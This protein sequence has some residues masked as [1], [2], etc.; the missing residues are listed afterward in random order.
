MHLSA[1][2]RDSNQGRRFPTAVSSYQSRVLGP[3]SLNILIVQSSSDCYMSCKM[4]IS[5]PQLMLANYRH[6]EI[7]V[8]IRTMNPLI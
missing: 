1:E 3:S 5:A 7:S 8:Y 6:I 2:W 4:Y